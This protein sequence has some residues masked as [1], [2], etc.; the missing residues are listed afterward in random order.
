M[1]QRDKRKKT[2]IIKPETLSL[3]LSIKTPTS[4]S[5][6][7]SI[8]ECLIPDRDRFCVLLVNSSPFANHNHCLDY[9]GLACS[10]CL[11][12]YTT[13]GIILSPLQ[14]GFGIIILQLPLASRKYFWLTMTWNNEEVFRLWRD[15]LPWDLGC[16]RH[17]DEWL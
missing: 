10:D 13:L 5:C 15:H 1:Q 6:I 12:P 9:G 11:F 8:N 7:V 4:L 3:S 14:S 2:D 16:T 17:Q